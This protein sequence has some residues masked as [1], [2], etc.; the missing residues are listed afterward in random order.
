MMCIRL[1]N[2]H[3]KAPFLSFFYTPGADVNGN[4]TG[5]ILLRQVTR[6]V[7]CSAPNVQYNVSWGDTT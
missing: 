4:N 1:K 7:A 3:L 5:L 6:C 2:S